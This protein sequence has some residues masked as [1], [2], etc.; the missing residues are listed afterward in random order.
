MHS[1]HPAHAHK[2]SAGHTN[3][4][5]LQPPAIQ[6]ACSVIAIVSDLSSTHNLANQRHESAQIHHDDYT[7]S[8]QHLQV[9]GDVANLLLLI[10]VL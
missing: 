9:T 8:T 7:S 1:R 10:C 5:Y 3:T 6:L 4:A 2:A